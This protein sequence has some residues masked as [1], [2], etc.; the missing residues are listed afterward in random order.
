MPNR[1]LTWY[2]LHVFTSLGLVT[3]LAGL[4][5]TENW[6]VIATALLA[7]T[8]LMTAHAF[9]MY[10]L[11]ELVVLRRIVGDF[12]CVRARPVPCRA[13]GGRGGRC[14]CGRGVCSR[15]VR[16]RCARGVHACTRS[17]TPHTA[18]RLRRLWT[19]WAAY[20]A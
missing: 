20:W 3:V 8:R 13:L 15:P 2:G 4:V 19:W 9:R 16:A 12:K 6:L 1:R 17:R 11:R 7:A 14:G 5:G 18:P 10:G